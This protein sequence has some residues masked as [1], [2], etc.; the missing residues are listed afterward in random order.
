MRLIHLSDPHLASLHDLKLR[1]LRG[2]RVLGYQS[3]YRKRRH[4]YTVDVL[5]PVTRAVRG[6]AA[7]VIVVSGDL[8]HLGMADELRQ[9]GEWLDSLGKPEQVLVIPGNH[10]CY[11]PQSWPLIRNAFGPYLA[12][13]GE[14]EG[15]RD[16]YPLLRRSG[17]VAII[18]AS[19]AEP[20]A[21]WSASGSLGRAQRQ[22]LEKVLTQARESFTFLV[23]HHP[24]LPDMAPRRKSLRDAPALAELL[25]RH[26]PD[27]VLHGHLH[28][29]RETNGA[30]T[31]IFCTAPPS[32]KRPRAP[33]SYRVFDVI[34]D[35]A[36]YRVV[37]RLKCFN[38]NAMEVADE[39]TW[40]ADRS[41]DPRERHDA[42]DQ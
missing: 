36:G 35:P 23:L 4:Q 20:T 6:E 5:R 18:A 13:Q 40:V 34:K 2:K 31:R 41:L 7:D 24:P 42:A 9:A 8:V 15:P 33:A 12:L 28:A 38:G 30:P 22:R 21:W 25:R 29:N 10:D 1:N 37:M 14:P 16:G 11:H 26:A 3:W 32:S 39:Q 27:V 17:E 19:T